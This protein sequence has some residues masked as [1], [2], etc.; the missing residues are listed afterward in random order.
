MGLELYALAE[1]WCCSAHYPESGG[2]PPT[3]VSLATGSGGL[4]AQT[5]AA[6][7]HPGLLP[8]FLAGPM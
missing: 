7:N 8:A 3:S 6:V 2:A 1:G 4:A 5:A